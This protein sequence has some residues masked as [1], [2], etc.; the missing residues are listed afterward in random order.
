[1]WVVK[2]G[3]S[4]V[5]T[6]H[7]RNWLQSLDRHG[8]GKAILVPGGGPFAKQVRIAQTQWEFSD[9]IAHRM[10]LLA[11]DQYAWMLAGLCKSLVPALSETA[12]RSGLEATMIPVWVPS[13]MLSSRS[14]IAQDWSVT[15]DSLA[16]WLALRVGAEQLIL[17][18]SV[19]RDRTRKSP[20][21]LRRSGIVDDAFPAFVAQAKF[22]VRVLGRGDDSMIERL[23]GVA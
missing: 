12:I 8:R 5:R 11:M 2:L 18:K 20:E 7:L 15:S 21:E 16:A 4:L 14:D 13:R 23:M 6:Q 3:G 22:T 9:Q 17:V 10:A 1:M 19:A